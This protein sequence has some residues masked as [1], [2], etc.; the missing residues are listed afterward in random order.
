LLF[1]DNRWKHNLFT[2]IQCFKNVKFNEISYSNLTLPV[3]L[4][5]T[6]YKQ[7]SATHCSGPT[8]IDAETLPGCICQG[9]TRTR[10]AQRVTRNFLHERFYVTD[11]TMGPRDDLSLSFESN[12]RRSRLVT[13]PFVTVI[14]ITCCI[15]CSIIL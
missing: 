12:E 5:D 1:L 6:A 8:C 13:K 9:K 4:V 15:I 10:H 2:E 14:I 7:I 11:V 3:F